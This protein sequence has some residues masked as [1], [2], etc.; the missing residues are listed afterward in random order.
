MLRPNIILLP[1]SRPNVCMRV[2]MEHCLPLWGPMFWGFCQW[3]IVPQI[4]YSGFPNSGN[5]AWAFFRVQLPITC[6]SQF[7]GT[8]SFWKAALVAIIDSPD[9][10]RG[11]R[12]LLWSMGCLAELSNTFSLSSVPFFV[13]SFLGVFSSSQC[14]PSH[15]SLDTHR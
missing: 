11:Q 5:G 14:V 9:F 15:F 7:S 13:S 1:S 3:P 10:S 2:L 12:E 4:T 6:R 8:S